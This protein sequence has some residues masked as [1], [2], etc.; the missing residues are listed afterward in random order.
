MSADPSPELKSLF[1]AALDE[2]EKKSGSDLIQHQT[3]NQLI[4]CESVAS[5]IDVL[6]EQTKAFQNSRGDDRGT[7][8]ECIKRTVDILRTL[9]T[10]DVPV[11]GVTL[12]LC[13]FR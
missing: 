1:Q 8:I 4:T 6:Q 10:S 7:L 9:S 11:D 13:L 5:V 12:V 2:F 3:F